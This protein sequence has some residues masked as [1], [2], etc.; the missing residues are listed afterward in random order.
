MG[1]HISQAD[2][3]L[4]ILPLYLLSARITG[5]DHYTWSSVVL[6]DGRRPCTPRK[7][8]P[9]QA[10]PQSPNHCSFVFGFMSDKIDLLVKLF[11]WVSVSYS[12]KEIHSTLKKIHEWMGH[13]SCVGGGSLEF[14][15]KI[16]FELKS[17]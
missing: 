11:L 13:I 16:T 1:F 4:L 7:H 3:E 5:L 2:L 8:Y 17:D 6:G 15:E 12:E 14:F 10:I 9:N